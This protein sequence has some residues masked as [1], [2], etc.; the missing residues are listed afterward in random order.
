MRTFFPSGCLLARPRQSK[1]TECS[2]PLETLEAKSPAP[3]RL[4]SESRLIYSSVAAVLLSEHG[5]GA[6]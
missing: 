6:T 5:H 3:P 2:L 1:A 4:I